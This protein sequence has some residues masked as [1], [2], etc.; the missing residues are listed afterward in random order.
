VA[1][2]KTNLYT[3]TLYV[4][5]LDSG[6]L[7]NEPR[8]NKGVWVVVPNTTT[9]DRNNTKS[10]AAGLGGTFFNGI[11]DVEIHPNTGQIYFTAKGNSRTYSFTD[12][13]NNAINFET[14]VGSKD[15]RIT[16]VGGI[17]SEPW[18][19]GNDNLTFD[20]RGNLYV[21]RDGGRDHVWL[22]RNDHTQANPKVEVFMTNPSGSEPTGMTFSPDERFMFIS[23]QS[24][25]SNILQK[26]V[27]GNNY[28]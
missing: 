22:I 7:N 15:Y 11:E 5:K 9:T 18:G 6:L 1:L 25:A 23:I 16:S 2:Q 21:L 26:D 20:I 12:N 10:L 4:L 27:R 13:G 14:F 17:V 19:S 3:G 24:P 8:A 28:A